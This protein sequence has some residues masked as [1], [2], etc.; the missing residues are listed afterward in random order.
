MVVCLGGRLVVVEHLEEALA[1]IGRH[2]LV[3]ALDE[4]G[5]SRGER[6]SSESSREGILRFI[7]HDPYAPLERESVL[8]SRRARAF[9]G[10]S[11]T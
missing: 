7:W 4:R 5:A 9:F 10:S 11:K 2:A 6:S 3:G 1:H 8:L